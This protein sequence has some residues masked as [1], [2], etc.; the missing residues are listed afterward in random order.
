[1]AAETLRRHKASAQY[2][3]VLQGLMRQLKVPV[4]ETRVSVVQIFGQLR[5]RR[6]VP[7][8]IS[9]LGSGGR[10]LVSTAVSALAVICGQEFGVDMEAW[11][12]WWSENQSN[13]RGQWL[14]Q[15]LLHKNPA[16]QNVCNRE[17]E[18]SS[19]L[20]MGY[21]IKWAPAIKRKWQLA[22]QLASGATR[23]R[24]LDLGKD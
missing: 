10:E 22:G 18:L 14:C 23:S 8:L 5:E 4:L 20:S 16:I 3:Q 12:A 21:K 17:L 9:L 15:G 11:Q 13:D 19:G 6:A 2:T 1:M 24:F 7:V